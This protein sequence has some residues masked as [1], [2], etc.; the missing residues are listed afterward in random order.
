MTL[1]KQLTTQSLSCLICEMGLKMV[2]DLICLLCVLD[3]NAGEPHRAWRERF[4]TAA[5][6]K[7]QPRTQCFSH[8]LSG[9]QESPV[10][11]NGAGIEA[12]ASFVLGKQD[13][14]M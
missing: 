7:H 14:T 8:A 5:L 11:T 13:F 1:N 3:G 6:H 4:H 10:F 9:G 12:R 2:I